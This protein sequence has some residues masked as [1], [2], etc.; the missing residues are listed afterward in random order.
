MY[1]MCEKLASDVSMKYLAPGEELS[2]DNLISVSDDD[3]VQVTSCCSPDAVTCIK[4]I[5]QQN[6]ACIV[7]QS[8]ASNAAKAVACLIVMSC[9]GDVSRVL[10]GIAAA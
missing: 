5:Q 7:A 8:S 2:P 6:I 9:A 3:D 1:K 10:E 4:P